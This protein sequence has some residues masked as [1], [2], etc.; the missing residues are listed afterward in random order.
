MNTPNTHATP[1]A[2]PTSTSGDAFHGPSAT[3]QNPAFSQT[4]HQRPATWHAPFD[5]GISRT[6]SADSNEVHVTTF[7]EA[8]DQIRSGEYAKQI[9]AVRKKYQEGGKEAEDSLGC[10]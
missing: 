8:M 10:P 9:A 5:A 4:V 3:F 6:E 7:R 1:E 2:V